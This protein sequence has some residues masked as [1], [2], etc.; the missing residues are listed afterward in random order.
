MVG[1]VP[2]DLDLSM[3]MVLCFFYLQDSWTVAP[4]N[5][6]CSSDVT[7]LSAFSANSECING[8]CSCDPCYA[9][10][11]TD[12]VSGKCIIH[13]TNLIT[14]NLSPLN[15]EMNFSSS[16]LGMST[17]KNK[18]EPSHLD[19]HCLHQYLF[20]SAGLKELGQ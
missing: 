10:N 13:M 15:S 6:S 7:C 9:Y 11:D 19:L 17:I 18:D 20:W 2:A 16:K 12:C 3:S 1:L 4:P 5:V 8:Y 14:C